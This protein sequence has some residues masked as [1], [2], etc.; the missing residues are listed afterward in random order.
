MYAAALKDRI[1]NLPGEQFTRTWEC[2]EAMDEALEKAGPTAE[3][4]LTYVTALHQERLA[5]LLVMQEGRIKHMA[6]TALQQHEN[7]LSLATSRNEA[8][9]KIAKLE[10]RIAR[11]TKK[12]KKSR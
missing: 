8:Y 6:N 10:K 7:V 11:L 9:D 12:T 4:A 1:R 2:I 3:L 5:Q